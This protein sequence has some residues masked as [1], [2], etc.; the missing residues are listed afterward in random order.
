ME[1]GSGEDG[2]ML[3]RHRLDPNSMLLLEIRHTQLWPAT[4]GLV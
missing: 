1:G 3:E 2:R 4:A